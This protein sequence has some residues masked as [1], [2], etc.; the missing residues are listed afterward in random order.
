MGNWRTVQIVG[1]MLAE[2]VDALR[3][4]LN[5]NFRFDLDNPAHLAQNKKF[6]PLSC[7]GGLCGIG[8]WPD[9]SINVVGNLAERDF[10]EHDVA[11]HLATLAKVAPSLGVL[12]HCGGDYEDEKCVATVVLF[13]GIAVVRPPDIERIG[14]IPKM[15][16]ENNMFRQLFGSYNRT[17]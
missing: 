15:Q 8:S 2:E 13:E 17:L 5:Q 16:I 3:A 4:E 10:S 9:T 11:E 1:G 6:G 14:A 12:V 7:T